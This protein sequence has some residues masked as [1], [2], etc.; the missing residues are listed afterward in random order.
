M[1]TRT[2]LA[3]AMVAS[4]AV[5]QT[6]AVFEVTKAVEQLGK[7]EDYNNKLT[8]QSAECQGTFNGDAT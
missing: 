5:A 6:Q 1:F 3:T 2:T 7:E 4:V 8:I